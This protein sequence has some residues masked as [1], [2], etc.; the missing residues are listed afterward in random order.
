MPVVDVVRAGLSEI[1][2]FA[3][4]ELTDLGDAAVAG[5]VATDLTHLLAELLENATTFSPP[6]SKVEVLRRPPG[7]GLPAGRRGSRDRHVRGADGRGQ[8]R[9]DELA[10]FDRSPS[11]LLGL[12]VVG[13][14]A[15]R[16]GITVRLVESVTSGVTAK[17]L[18]PVPLRRAG[19]PDDAPGSRPG[20]RPH[21]GGRCR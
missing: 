5:S 19:G 9:I 21:P 3:R 16:H 13:R 18:I 20:Q 12:Y 17:V 14:L 2:D 4:V 8:H 7:R 1:E 11:K 15:A 10:R 6:S